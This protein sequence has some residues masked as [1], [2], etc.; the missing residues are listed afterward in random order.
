MTGSA[1]TSS[2]GREK[3]RR[4]LADVV[5][6][7]V[8][9]EYGYDF[10]YKSRPNWDSYENLLGFSARARADLRDMKPRDLIGIQSFL[11]VQ[12]SDKCEE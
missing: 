3:F 7:R 8:S 2:L 9:E 4:L 6:R 12:G 5:T 1:P 10:R 11:W